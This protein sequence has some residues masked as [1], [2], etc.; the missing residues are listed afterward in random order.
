MAED[1]GRIQASVAVDDS[2]L[3]QKLTRLRSSI[4][5]LVAEM[6]VLQRQMQQGTGDT[7][8]MADT[9]DVL[10]SA[11]SQ[12]ADKAA[13]MAA[14]THQVHTGLDGIG[15]AS[16]SAAMEIMAVGQ[17]ADDMQ[18]AFAAIVNHV[19]QVATA[20]GAGAGLAGGL[21]VATVAANQLIMRWDDLA[22]TFGESKTNT[23]AE[24]MEELGKETSRPAEEAARLINI[25][26]ESPQISAHQNIRDVNA[27][28]A[29][30]VEKE[31]LEP[32]DGFRAGEARE[33]LVDP[34]A[35]GEEGDRNV[36]PMAS[37]Y[38]RLAH[39]TQ[40]EQR[41]GGTLGGPAYEQ[42]TK[43]VVGDDS[44]LRKLQDI[45]KT[46][47]EIRKLYAGTKTIGVKRRR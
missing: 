38:D 13:T 28:Q 15:K 19:P 29:L 3:D 17:H 23:A 16:S 42:S 32:D 18:N 11:H 34:I 46:L 10:S 14:A 22:D 45:G 33:K 25:K 6:Q 20:L 7:R 43:A 37:L 1:V 31:Q 4:Q 24:G 26:R 12:F 44:H 21:S 27:S 39:L 2:G 47:E 30:I 36:A 9:L 35:G 8:V 40:V 41:G 5:Q